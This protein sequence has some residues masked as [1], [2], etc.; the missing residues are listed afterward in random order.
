MSEYDMQKFAQELKIIIFNSFGKTGPLCIPPLMT[1]G[2][3]DFLGRKVP[4][5]GSCHVVYFIN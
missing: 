5:S 2:L 1:G 3:V 4:S